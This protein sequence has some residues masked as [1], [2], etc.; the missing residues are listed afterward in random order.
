[1]VRPVRRHLRSQPR[2]IPQRREGP[3]AVTR[4][5]AMKSVLMLAI[6]LEVVAVGVQVDPR[7]M[8]PM[9]SGRCGCFE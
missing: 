1:M 4:G 5:Y 7:H 2:K 6:M 9:I 8:W 3:Q